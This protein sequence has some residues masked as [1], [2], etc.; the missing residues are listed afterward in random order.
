ME[1]PKRICERCKRAHNITAHHIFPKGFFRQL[2]KGKP[3]YLCRKC[4]DELEAI[5]PRTEILDAY[6]YVVIAARF[7]GKPEQ[8]LAI[9]YLDML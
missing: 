2:P 9:V 4:H 6:E 5:I 8:E 3:F 7:I 1:K